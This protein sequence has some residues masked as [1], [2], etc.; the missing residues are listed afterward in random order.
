ML[1]LIVLL[2]I[3]FWSV[4]DINFEIAW[5]GPSLW[6][7]KRKWHKLLPVIHLH[8]SFCTGVGSFSCLHC[9]CFF[10]PLQSAL[11]EVS[12]VSSLEL[13]ILFWCVTYHASIQ[14]VKN[15]SQ[16]IIGSEWSFELLRSEFV[17]LQMNKWYSGKEWSVWVLDMNLSSKFCRVTHKKVTARA[18]LFKAVLS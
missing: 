13:N 10:S 3:L 11:R 4:N 7:P 8:S 16:L 5:Y 18:R 12:D 9:R 2:F 17:D 6:P 1:F 15:W 14:M